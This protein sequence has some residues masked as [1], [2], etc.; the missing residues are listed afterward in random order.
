MVAKRRLFGKHVVC[1]K[2]GK[3]TITSDRGAPIVLRQRRAQTVEIPGWSERAD[4]LLLRE[5]V[6]YATVDPLVASTRITMFSIIEEGGV[7][8]FD[9]QPKYV[10]TS[11]SIVQ[12]ATCPGPYFAVLCEGGTVPCGYNSA[13]NECDLRPNR[14]ERLDGYHRYIAPD[15]IVISTKSLTVQRH[16]VLPPAVMLNTTRPIQGHVNPMFQI[17]GDLFV[18]IT[19][20]RT[21]TTSMETFVNSVFMKRHNDMAMTGNGYG[22]LDYDKDPRYHGVHNSNKK[23]DVL[24][25]EASNAAVTVVNLNTGEFVSQSDVSACV[26]DFREIDPD[27]HPT[28]TFGILLS[29]AT[30]SSSCSNEIVEIVDPRTY[31]VHY[32]NGATVDIAGCGQDTVSQLCTRISEQTGHPAATIHLHTKD[33]QLQAHHTLMSIGHAD[34]IHI[35]VATPECVLVNRSSGEHQHI[36]Y[37]PT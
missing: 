11:S 25:N 34:K 24:Y 2:K 15:V 5:V 6:I 13:P 20:A 3:F 32:M 14:V 22:D 16:C 9:P 21:V 31:T 23:G 4:I 35:V 30:S 27:E 29:H 12:I 8:T 19:N 37:L 10:T 1:Y 7:V 26:G 18:I 17:R 36:C 33:V 28:P